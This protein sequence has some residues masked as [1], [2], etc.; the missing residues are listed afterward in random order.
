MLARVDVQVKEA[1]ARPAVVEPGALHCSVWRGGSCPMRRAG[2]A[3]NQLEQAA[4]LCLHDEGAAVP[5]IGNGAML[6]VQSEQ[7]LAKVE[8]T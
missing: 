1:A 3:D 6:D 2:R 7:G 5:G 8:F 4:A